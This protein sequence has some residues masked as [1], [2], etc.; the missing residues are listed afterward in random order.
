MANSVS[1]FV[2]TDNSNFTRQFNIETVGGDQRQRLAEMLRSNAL[3]M[4]QGQMVSG[5]YVPPSWSQNLAQL[6][7]TAVG[8]LG[9]AAL[10]RERAQKTAEALKRFEGVEEQV[11]L[12][13]LPGVTTQDA[14]M[15][16]GQSRPEGAPM[17]SMANPQMMQRQTRM[18]PL[19]QDEQDMALLNL[20]QIN[21]QAGQIYGTLLGTRAT[22]A[23]RAAEKA[24]QRAWQQAENEKN[25][26]AR[27][28]QIRMMA[29]LRPPA[30]EP[31][32]AVLG[33]DG[34]PVMVPRGQA[35][36]MTPFNAQTAGGAGTPTARVREATEA[37]DIVNQAAPLIRQ[38]TSSGI[39]AGVDWA[40]SLIGVS[41]KG[42]DVAAQLKVLGGALVSKMPKMSGPQ[43]DKDVM[44]Y[45]EMAG[46][47]GDPT[48]PTSQK[49]AALQTIYN[50]NAKY[51]GF[52]EQILSFEPSIMSGY[53]EPPSGAVRVKGQ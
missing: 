36:G 41:P 37:I 15:A 33:K 5:W 42:A 31:L 44:L 30:Q 18:R 25:R 9:G 50:L 12:E 52:P 23:E 6:A 19:T 32:V 45:K 7:N 48:V 17:Q 28:D 29:A 13:N 27:E 24:D 46:R 49:E 21:P 51:A 26:Q 20:A 43:S 10:D 3:N 53:G 39:G 22:R 16:E 34:N 47:L 8:V 1:P 38:S 11:P 4:P 2:G 40:G 35:V 14:L